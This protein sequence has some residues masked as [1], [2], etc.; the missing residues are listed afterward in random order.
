MYK[1]DSLFCVCV[2]ACKM[3]FLVLAES[4]VGL[5]REFYCV[6]LRVVLTCILWC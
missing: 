1:W 3:G 2:C 6:S 4:F 5:T